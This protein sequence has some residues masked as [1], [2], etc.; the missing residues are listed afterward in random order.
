MGDNLLYVTSDNGL[1]VEPLS[2]FNA[3]KMEQEVN[4]AFSASFISFNLSNNP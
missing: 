4:G 3:L 1:Q 2:Q